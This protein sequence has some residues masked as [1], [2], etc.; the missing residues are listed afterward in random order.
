[1]ASPHILLTVVVGAVVFAVAPAVTASAAPNVACGTPLSGADV[2]SIDS[3]SDIAGEPPQPALQ[4][5]RQ[6]VA[7]LWAVTNTLVAQKDRRGLFPL[8]LAV[9]NGM[10]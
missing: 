9:T 1:M 4:R 8:G 10:R 6:H 7:R 5:L 2:A 3:A